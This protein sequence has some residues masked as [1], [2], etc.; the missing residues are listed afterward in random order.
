MAKSLEEVLR[1]FQANMGEAMCLWLLR[2][3]L[4]SEAFTSTEIHSD[5]ALLREWALVHGLFSPPRGTESGTSMSTLTG[6]VRLGNVSLP[7]LYMRPSLAEYR[8][9]GA[10]TGFTCVSDL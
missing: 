6:S 4:Y 8:G 5:H 10:R 1:E 7:G 9:R 2:M 3:V